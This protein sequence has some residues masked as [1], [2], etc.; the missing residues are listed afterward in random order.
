M[1]KNNPKLIVIDT[2]VYVDAL[3]RGHAQDIDADTDRAERSAFLLNLVDQ[4]KYRAGLAPMVKVELNASSLLG[5]HHSSEKIQDR[6]DRTDA[7]FEGAGHVYLEHDERVAN[8]A[9]KLARESLMK[10]PDA[11][12]VATAVVFEATYLFSWDDKVLEQQGNPL[13]SKLQILKPQ[14]LGVVQQALFGNGFVRSVAQ[15]K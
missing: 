9:A 14:E 3:Y 12:I 5:T 6:K 10:G 1:T 8:L 13:I 2:C 7:Y 4:G 11:L 15:S